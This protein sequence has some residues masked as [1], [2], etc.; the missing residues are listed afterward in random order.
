MY[1]S[2]ESW[3][4]VVTKPNHLGQLSWTNPFTNRLLFDARLSVTMQHYDTTKHREIANPRNVPRISESGNTAGAD[5]VA[6]RVNNSAGGFGTS[7]TSGSLNNAGSELRN[8]DSYRS[9]ASAS[10]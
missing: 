3:W 5:E 9:N 1:T 6:S 4:S 10:S 8:L 2:P 7:L